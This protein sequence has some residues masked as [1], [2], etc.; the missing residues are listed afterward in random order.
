MVK[1]KTYSIGTKIKWVGPYRRGGCM[2]NDIGK[3]G[4]IV[5][6]MDG[7]PIIYLPDSETVSCFSTTDIPATIQCC[8][9][10]IESIEPKVGEQLEFSFM[11]E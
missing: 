5:R 10:N 11:S 6:I 3:T 9:F 1:T 8:W 7:F 4:V 2:N